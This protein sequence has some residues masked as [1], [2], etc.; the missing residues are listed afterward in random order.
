MGD[1]NDVQNTIDADT[2]GTR[3]DLTESSIAAETEEQTASQDESTESAP[4]EHD[5]AAVPEAET[6]EGAVDAEQPAAQDAGGEDAAPADEQID[7]ASDENA[8]VRLRLKPP[9]PVSNVGLLPS[10]TTSARWVTNIGT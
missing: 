8:G 9:Y 2:E 7:S 4:A 5:P 10:S 3:D 1:E 6:P